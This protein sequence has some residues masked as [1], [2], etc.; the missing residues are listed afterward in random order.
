MYLFVLQS[1]FP[2]TFSRPNV[3]KEVPRSFCSSVPMFHR[4][5]LPSPGSVFCL[6]LGVSSGFAQP[7]TGQVTEASYPVTG[8]A[9]PEVTPSKTQKT[10]SGCSLVMISSPYTFPNRM[11]HLGGTGD[12]EALLGNEGTGEYKDQDYRN[13]WKYLGNIEIGKHFWWV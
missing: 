2:Q 7:I 4:T 9:H 8:R 12:W 6:L 3:L 13:W 1:L 10:V 5:L 11:K